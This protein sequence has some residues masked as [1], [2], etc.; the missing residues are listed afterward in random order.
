MRVGPAQRFT[1]SN[2]CTYALHRWLSITTL[3]CLSFPSL[4]SISHSLPLHPLLPR[5]P[6]FSPSHLKSSILTLLSPAMA[7]LPGVQNSHSPT[8]DSSS[9]S[10]LTLIQEQLE[11]CSEQL[12]RPLPVGPMRYCDE[13]VQVAALPAC[14][15]L[16]CLEECR[17]HVLNKVRTAWWHF[18]RIQ[19]FVIQLL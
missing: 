15:P 4:F 17:A 1:L 13:I 8:F 6:L 9:Q 3:L 7:A 10:N 11:M 19:F 14:Q 16:S 5:S 2:V 12:P 18:V